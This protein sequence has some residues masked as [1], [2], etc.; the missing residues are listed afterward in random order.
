M[1]ANLKNRL[2]K[3]NTKLSRYGFKTIIDFDAIH[4]NQ[5]FQPTSGQDG[6]E[7]AI[8]YYRPIGMLG[9]DAMQL[10]NRRDLNHIGDTLIEISR[11]YSGVDIY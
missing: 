8:L 10:F 6:G 3:V 5:V 1:K 9:I 4:F 2:N 7:K 11:T